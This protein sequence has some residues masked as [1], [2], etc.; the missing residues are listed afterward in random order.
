MP[1]RKS[2]SDGKIVKPEDKIWRQQFDQ[3][4]KEDHLEKLHLL[5]LDDEEAEELVQDFEEVKQ[6]KKGKVLQEMEAEAQPIEN[7]RE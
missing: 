7:T 4:S 3:L 1:L 2:H 5:G 6:G